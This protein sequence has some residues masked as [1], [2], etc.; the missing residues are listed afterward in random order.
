MY[1]AVDRYGQVLDV[2][3]SAR[4]DAQAVRRFFKRALTMFKVIPTEVVTDAAGVYPAVLAE[5]IRSVCDHVE[6][7]ANNRIEAD[8]SQLKHRLRPTRGLPTDQ[9]L[10]QVRSR[11][12][13]RVSRSSSR[14]AAATGMAT[15]APTRPRAAPPMRTATSV[16]V[17]GT[18]TDRPMI[19]GTRR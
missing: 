18:S 7:S 19:R 8:H 5:L 12:G 4:R 17:A 2:P 13:R 3:V 14:S 15:S 16:T 6:R 11:R 9:G 10:G 1:R